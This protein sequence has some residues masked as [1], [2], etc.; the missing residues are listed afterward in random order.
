MDKNDSITIGWCDNGTT[1]GEFSE[2]LIQVALSG[3]S[4]GFPIH[5]SIRVK[6]NQ[7]ARQRQ[8]LIDYWYDN[9]KTD[10]LFWVDSD[11]VLNL[12]IWKKICDTADKDIRPMV[13][14]VYFIS[15][16]SHGSLPIILPCIFDDVDEFVIKYHHPL[17]ADQILKVDC[18][19]MGLIIIHRSVVSK[20]REKYGKENF[21]FAENDLV[22]NNF[23]GEDI[24]FFRKCKKTKIPLYAHTG[25]IAKHIKKVA[26]DI[27]YYNLIW[28]SL[29]PEKIKNTPPN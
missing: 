20:L 14:G 27:D 7:I 24:S 29:E 8:S 12:N 9:T 16:E 15:K 1:D 25:A 2:G 5:S 18:A 19:G 6:G 13:T 28:D 3:A 26:W 11:I 10:W 21:L 4:V 17:P 23:I 22:G